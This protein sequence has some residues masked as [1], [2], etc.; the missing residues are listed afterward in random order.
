MTDDI[1]VDIQVLHEFLDDAAKASLPKEGECLSIL[2]P[3]ESD[4]T[5]A[6]ETVEDLY[7]I[8]L[9][10]AELKNDYALNDGSNSEE[11]KDRKLL[12]KQ[13]RK[14]ER[15][16]AAYLN[17][18]QSVQLDKLTISIPAIKP[19]KETAAELAAEPIKEPAPGGVKQYKKAVAQKAQ[20]ASQRRFKKAKALAHKVA[21]EQWQ[22]N[23][24]KTIT[25]VAYAALISIRANLDTVGLKEAPGEAALKRWVKEVGSPE[26]SP[27]GK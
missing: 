2:D 23:P 13:I 10:L 19:V 27:R 16:L 15:V 20:E 24:K 4:P 1:D 22:L 3:L 17:I 9:A 14:Y 5:E 11:R 25:D 7:Q 8:H 6:V 21:R 18:D 26:K 12:K